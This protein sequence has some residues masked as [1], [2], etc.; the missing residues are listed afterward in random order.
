M[1]LI[2]NM[3]GAGLAFAMIMAMSASPALGQ[4]RDCCSAST[5]EFY[6]A[7]SKAACEA[8]GDTHAVTTDPSQLAKLQPCYQSVMQQAQQANSG[9]FPGMPSGLPMPGGQSPFTP[10]SSTEPEYQCCNTQTRSFAGIM[11]EQACRDL[12]SEFVP[13]TPENL[14]ETQM[15]HAASS[16]GGGGGSAWDVEDYEP[17]IENG[18]MEIWASDRRPRDFTTFGVNPD[19]PRSYP[20]DIQVAFQSTDAHTGDYS[21]RIKNL[22]L[23]PQLP[24]E[25]GMAKAYLGE[26]AFVTPGGIMTCE[27]P[28]PTETGASVG[29]GAG[30]EMFSPL[31]ADEVKSHVCGA[32]KGYIAASDELV[33]ALTVDGGGSITGGVQESFTRSSSD[34]IEFAMPMTSWQGALPDSANVGISARLMARNNQVG[35]AKSPITEVWL[36]SIHFCDPMQ[37]IAYVPEVISGG[38]DTEIIES[39]EDTLGVQT[40]V[41]LDNDDE[42]SAYDYLDEDGVA[43]DDELVRLRL[44]LPMNSF[45]KVQFIASG[46]GEAI[47]L[48]DDAAKTRKFTLHNQELEVEELL[49]ATGDGSKFIRDVWVEAIKASESPGDQNFEFVFKNRR[50][51]DRETRDRVVM[52]ALG[53]ESIEIEGD[54]NGFDLNNPD[55]LDDD[56]NYGFEGG[57]TVRNLRVFPGKRWD[58]DRPQ[59]APNDTVKVTVTLNVEPPRPVEF[60]FR[61]FDMDDPSAWD[62]AVDTL[63]SWE[64]NRGTEPNNWGQFVG[65]D[66]EHFALEFDGK[67]ASFEFRVTKQPG[68]NF[69][70]VGGGD[71]MTLMNLHNNDGEIADKFEERSLYQ[72]WIYDPDVMDAESDPREARIPEHDKYVSD[73]ITV[74]RRLWFEIDEMA[75][76]EGNEVEATIIGIRDCNPATETLDAIVSDCSEAD[77]VLQWLKI[78]K[79]L[80]DE[81]PDTSKFGRSHYVDNYRLGGM[82]IDGGT[83]GIA[84]NTANASGPDEILVFQSRG[85][86]GFSAEQVLN[87]TVTIRDDDAFQNGDPVPEIDRSRMETVFKEAYV[88]P[89][90][91]P[92]YPVERLPFRLH[93]ITDDESELH[94]QMDPTFDAKGYDNDEDFWIAYLIN[95]FQ[96]KLDEDGDSEGAAIA[97]QADQGRGVGTGYGAFIYQESGRELGNN[98]GNNPGWRVSDIAPH[99]VG[100][101]FGGAHH[102]PGLMSDRVGDKTDT[103]DPVT[104]DAIRSTKVP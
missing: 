100:H 21:V 80:Y 49:R 92:V 45:G 65:D 62:D 71:V 54:G 5:N 79:N 87:K 50:D 1:M 90:P 47:E 10:A 67:I 29:A 6:A 63:S 8:A 32:Y 37:L 98:F 2:S 84:R 41:N 26:N 72:L 74:W 77:R 35:W 11:G 28:C 23:Y 34:W 20:L 3:R 12:G 66:K 27:E 103:F 99:E 17:N 9:A 73:M 70:I 33:I 24:P 76:V 40:F 82:T 58:N 53:I 93:A 19:I 96:G 61:A 104:L 52:T 101:M 14:A 102:Q 7:G 64:D 4:A 39:E 36:D 95:G 55:T 91:D 69:R 44:E 81:L 83:Y 51:N 97:G 57:S 89:V 42:D 88:Y 48:W 46:V 38:T 75:D 94:T 22:D 56:P 85:I 86:P 18:G 60:R 78:D 59:G 25:A 68:D 16:G 31:R 13:D 43:G 30:L 15:C